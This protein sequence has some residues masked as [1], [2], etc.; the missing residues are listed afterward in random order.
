[1]LEHRNKVRK[2]LFFYLDVLDQE[3]DRLLGQLGNI[4]TKGMMIIS[5]TIIRPYQ[6]KEV[7]IQ[8]PDMKEF[9][10]KFIRVSL[11]TRWARLHTDSHLHCV[12]CK[13]L[14]VTEE[15]LAAI[16]IVE[17]MLAFDSSISHGI[18]KTT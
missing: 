10:Q 16:R 3:N 6:Q 18:E 7:L 1:M 15:N 13:F 14:S 12:G 4:S 11:E 17:K 9:E 2:N 5:T 8:L